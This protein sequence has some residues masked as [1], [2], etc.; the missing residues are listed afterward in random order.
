MS[1]LLIPPGGLD[2]ASFSSFFL[3]FFLSFLPFHSRALELGVDEMLGTFVRHFKS[4]F[5]F[6]SLCFLSLFNYLPWSFH[7]VQAAPLCRELG[8]S[9]DAIKFSPGAVPGLLHAVIE[10]VGLHRHHW[11][12]ASPTT[13]DT[14]TPVMAPLSTAATPAVSCSSPSTSASSTSWNPSSS[15]SSTSATC[16]SSSTSVVTS[17]SQAEVGGSSVVGTSKLTSSPTPAATSPVAPPA[18]SETLTVTASSRTTLASVPTILSLGSPETSTVC[19]TFTPPVTTFTEGTASLPVVTL[20]AVGYPTV[21][22]ASPEAPTITLPPAVP[23]PSVVIPSGDG[24]AAVGSSTDPAAAATSVSGTSSAPNP[25]SSP[26]PDTSATSTNMQSHSSSQVSQ[27]TSSPSPVQNA[28]STPKFSGGFI[29][30]VTVLSF[31]G[32]LSLTIGI[33]V[34]IRTRRSRMT[35]RQPIP[36]VE[37]LI[38]TSQPNLSS[39]FSV[40][41]IGSVRQSRL[42]TLM[43]LASRPL[44]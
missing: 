35:Q 26:P 31:L 36:D 41:T 44:T 22:L 30:L 15:A 27:P 24:P 18:S 3:S 20:P 32:L 42:S 11:D 6:Y 19:P 2:T 12:A 33:L 40:S 4:D 29:A 10:R 43:M 37:T 8:V 9:S 7:G 25:T 16:T 34:F 5:L 23:T 28:V 21:P 17:S 39:R 14:T 1:S 38:R 13:F